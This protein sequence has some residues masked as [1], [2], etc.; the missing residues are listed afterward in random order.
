MYTIEVDDKI[1]YHPLYD[2]PGYALINP[3]LTKERGRAGSLEFIMPKSNNQYNQ[4]QKITSLI[5]VYE[6]SKEIFR[7]RCMASERRFSEQKK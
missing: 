7:G 2:D 6:N 3:V 1:L 5:S 4:I